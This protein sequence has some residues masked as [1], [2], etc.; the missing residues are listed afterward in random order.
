MRYFKRNRY[1]YRTK[2]VLA[3]L[4][5]L[6]V[7]NPGAVHGQDEPIFEEL[8]RHFKQ[9]YLNVGVLVQAVGDVVFDRDDE[10]GNNGFSLGAARLR[11]QGELDFGF[12]Y[13]FQTEF[14]SGNPLLDARV[15]YR[16]S[17]GLIIDAGLFKTPFSAEFLIPAPAID[18]VNRSRVV[19]SL[20]PGRDVGI[21]LRGRTA[22]GQLFYSVGVFNGNGRQGIGGNDNNALLTAGRLAFSPAL[23]GASLEF[24]GNAAYSN[25]PT[26]ER[27]LLGVDFRFTQE[28]ILVSG[29]ALFAAFDPDLGPDRDPRGYHATFGYMLV[30]ER[31][32]ILFRLENFIP[33]NGSDDM[34]FF[35][36]GYNF[37][38]SR[39]IELQLNY[40]IPLEDGDIGNHRVLVNFQVAF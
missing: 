35:V 29:E 8:S 25:D 15:S 6:I 37:W 38:P 19:S 16:Y 23:E 4:A 26:R 39:P 14:T 3:F 24:G 21:A 33:D 12:G 28:R 10:P 40:L 30:P 34:P 1:L 13:F 22:S 36:F 20:A 9:P 17:R 18:F 27:T 2:G 7:L 5:L 32:Q 11:V 31:H